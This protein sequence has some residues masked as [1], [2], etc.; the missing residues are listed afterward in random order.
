MPRGPGSGDEL[1]TGICPPVTGDHRPVS[2]QTSSNFRLLG[3]HKSSTRDTSRIFSSQ[4][5]AV[6][7]E[8]VDRS[9]QVTI[10]VSHSRCQRRLFGPQGLEVHSMKVS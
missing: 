8:P 10:P 1:A 2:L 7:E 5:R 4:R 9:A 6:K 3:V